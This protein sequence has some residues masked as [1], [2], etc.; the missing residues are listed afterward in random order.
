MCFTFSILKGQE[1][2]NPKYN[3]NSQ[4]LEVMPNPAR[5]RMCKETHLKREKIFNEWR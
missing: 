4:L 2:T 3:Q 5:D 1:K